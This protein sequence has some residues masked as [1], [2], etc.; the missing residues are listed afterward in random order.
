MYFVALGHRTTGQFQW[1]RAR[2]CCL[3]TLYLDSRLLPTLLL[4]TAAPRR[5]CQAAAGRS[6]HA[7]MHCI[8]QLLLY[9]FL[10]LD[11]DK[12]TEQPSCY[13]FLFSVIYVSM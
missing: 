12:V 11:T 6:E 2:A 8:L 9:S 10:I 4:S 1:P 3:Y 13:T 5:A 7:T